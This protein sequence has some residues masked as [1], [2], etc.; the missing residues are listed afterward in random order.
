MCNHYS[1]DYFHNIPYSNYNVLFV[2]GHGADQLSGNHYYRQLIY[3]NSALYKISNRQE[4]TDLV[5]EMVED[6]QGRGGKF[7]GGPNYAS[8]EELSHKAVLSKIRQSLRDCT[9]GQD[10]GQE[11]GEQLEGEVAEVVAVVA[12]PEVV[13]VPEVVAVPA[14]VA[15]PQQYAIQENHSNN[16]YHESVMVDTEDQEENISWNVPDRHLNFIHYGRGASDSTNNSLMNNSI[17]TFDMVA[18]VTLMAEV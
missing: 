18:D 17:S 14:V 4:K 9:V 2:R 12:V 3:A 13:V 16:N 1:V 7:Y 10:Q 8:P 15:V 6:I 5:E 11:T